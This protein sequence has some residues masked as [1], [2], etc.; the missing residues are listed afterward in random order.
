MVRACQPGPAPG[1][2]YGVRAQLQRHT[3]VRRGSRGISRHH[4]PRHTASGHGHRERYSAT[5]APATG[6]NPWSGPKVVQPW[7]LTIAGVYGPGPKPW[8]TGK[9]PAAVPTW[10]TLAAVRA[11]RS[12]DRYPRNVW[13]QGPSTAIELSGNMRVTKDLRAPF[14]LSAALKRCVALPVITASDLCGEWARDLYWDPGT[15]SNAGC[16]GHP[17]SLRV[18]C[19]HPRH[20]AG[21]AATLAL[22]STPE[23]PQA[24]IV[25]LL[26]LGKLRIA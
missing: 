18:S 9:G 3:Y 14:I 10:A 13:L 25:S 19:L 4:C 24:D 17:E 11:C 15:Q 26:V 6:A 12:P 21:P 22:S 1:R 5:G 8:A 2:Y 16:D 20:R 7:E 23:L